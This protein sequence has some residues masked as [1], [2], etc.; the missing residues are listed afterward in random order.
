M[1][2][3]VFELI[4]TDNLSPTPKYLQ[5]VHSIVDAVDVGKIKKA[6]PASIYHGINSRV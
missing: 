1:R 3:R 4:D 5:L 6:W 2:S